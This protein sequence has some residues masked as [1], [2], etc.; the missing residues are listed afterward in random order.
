LLVQAVGDVAPRRADAASIFGGVRGALGGADLLFGQ[1]ECPLSDRGTPAPNA[2]LAMRTDP[3]VAA[4]LAAQ[5]FNVMSIA[6][7]HAMDFGALALADT[8]V[9]LERAGIRSCGAG[10]TI[11]DARRPA[12]VETGGRRVAVLAFCSIL[13]DG[14]VAEEARPG[15]APLRAFT[16]FHHVEHDQPGTPPR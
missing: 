11:A 4:V 16:H 2:K 14:Y 12:M 15:C 1:M 10:A 13:P 9:A 8:R 7:N 3:A 5:G 6:G